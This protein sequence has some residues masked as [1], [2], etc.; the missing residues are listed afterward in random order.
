MVE[1]YIGI[2]SNLG[3]RGDNICHALNLIAPKL[4]IACISSVFETEPEGYKEQPDFLN[5]VIKLEEVCV[6]ARELL[7]FLKSIESNLGR[8]EDFRNAPR[9]VDLDILFY[10]DVIIEE[11]DL[12]IPHPRLHERSFVLIPLT[13]IAG[14]LVHPCLHNNI[15]ELLSKLKTVGRISKVG[16]CQYD[17]SRKEYVFNLNRAKF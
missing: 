2:G 14:E 12:T 7:R 16:N 9:I 15:E 13:E 17:I 10:G 6:S 4:K 1:A 8:K 5:A 3:D 11:D